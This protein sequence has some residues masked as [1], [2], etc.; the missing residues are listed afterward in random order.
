MFFVP[1]WS[2][3]TA[4]YVPDAPPNA[5][6]IIATQTRNSTPSA[7]MRVTVPAAVND[8]IRN[9]AVIRPALSDSQ[10]IRRRPVALNSPVIIT[11]VTA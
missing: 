5:S 3:V 7:N 2:A 9:R 8:I 1:K 11:P 6:E 4:A 10:V